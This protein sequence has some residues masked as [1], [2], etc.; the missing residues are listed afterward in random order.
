MKFH[1]CQNDRYEIHT[2]KKF[3]THMRTERNIQR[4]CAYFVSGKFCSYENLVPV[5][6][7]IS[8]KMTNM[9]SIPFW[10]LFR[11]NSHKIGNAKGGGILMYVRDDIP[12]KLIPMHNSTI[13]GF[14]MELKLRK[15]TWLLQRLSKLFE[16]GV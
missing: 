4:V 6:N 16:W 5:W 8:V 15:K 10:V 11:L 14:F 1:F 3:Q 13:E 2:R 9:K 12:C 7:F